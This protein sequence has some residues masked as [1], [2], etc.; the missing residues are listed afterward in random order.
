MDIAVC[1]AQVPFMRGGA[2]LAMEN[3]DGAFESAG[4]RAELVR[5]P[6]AW[7]RERLFDAA[8]AWRMVPIDADIAVAINFP[9]YFL[10]H[11]R[12]VVWLFHQH[13]AAY[14]AIGQAWSDFT[15]E[16]EALEAQRMLTEWDTRAIEEATRVFTISQEVANRLLRFNGLAGEAL[17]HPP[18]LHDRLRGGSFGDYVFCPTRLEG[19]KRPGLMVEAAGHL[20]AN[21]RSGSP[22]AGP[23]TTRSS[24]MRAPAVA[25]IASSSWVSST[26]TR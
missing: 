17:Y 12:K 24:P 20:T 9:S 23:S 4:H 18:P 8:L 26:T 21:R 7:D 13:R 11:P 6:V 14:D 10:R 2:E 1:G 19:N 16:D 22:G 25:P 15:T 5:L 3:L